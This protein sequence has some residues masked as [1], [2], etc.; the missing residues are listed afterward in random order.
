MA[1][2]FILLTMPL[3]CPSSL[4][5]LKNYLWMMKFW[6]Y[7]NNICELRSEELWRMMIILHLI[8]H[9]AVDIYDFNIWNKLWKTV[10]P[11]SFQ[12]HKIKIISNHFNLL[13]VCP[14]VFSFIFAV[15]FIPS[16]ILCVVIFTVSLNLVAVTIAWILINFI[17]LLDD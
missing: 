3:T 17:T 12:N 14:S 13:Q 9:S 11:L 16:I 7:E 5:N 1:V 15:L 2:Q 6:I 8:L 4:C 10:R